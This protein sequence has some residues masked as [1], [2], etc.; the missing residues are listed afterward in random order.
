V[1]WM[2]WAAGLAVLVAA[3]VVLWTA[4]KNRPFMSG[5]VFR[6]SRLSRGNHLFPAQVGVTSASVV[7]YLPEWF[8]RQEETIHIVHVSSVRIDTS[9]FFSDVIIET[10]GGSNPI[11]CHGHHKRDAARMKQLIEQHQTTQYR[12]GGSAAVGA[13]RDCPFCAEPIKAAAKVCRYCGRD[14][15][16]R[17]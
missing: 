11:V 6:A 14:V 8:G 13:M 2:Y 7:K 1:A 5:D 17:S 10:T 4:R 12:V 3:L 15:G 16:V 9:L